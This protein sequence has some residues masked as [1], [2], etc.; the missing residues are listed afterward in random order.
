[1][2]LRAY[3]DNINSNIYIFELKNPKG[4]NH[5]NRIYSYRALTCIYMVLCLEHLW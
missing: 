4:Y 5:I 3:L 2:Q 1:M